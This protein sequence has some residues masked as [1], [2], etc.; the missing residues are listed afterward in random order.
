MS[1]S[2]EESHPDLHREITME[3]LKL[4]RKSRELG[5]DRLLTFV[6]ENQFKLDADKVNA[7]RDYINKQGNESQKSFFNDMFRQEV[8]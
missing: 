6:I 3:M 5:S 8:E 2:L 4:E 1:R 7:V